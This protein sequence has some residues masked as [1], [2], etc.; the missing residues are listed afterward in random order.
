MVG[1][2]PRRG[3][4]TKP[5]N[6][7]PFYWSDVRLISTNK[8]HLQMTI[9]FSGARTLLVRETGFS[10]PKSLIRWSKLNLCGTGGLVGGMKEYCWQPPVFLSILDLTLTNDHM[11][12]FT[13]SLVPEGALGRDTL[14]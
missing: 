11:V 9:S 4:V 5:L 7:G 2:S 6:L 10:S 3:V 14:G 8:M 13:D 12:P 1:P